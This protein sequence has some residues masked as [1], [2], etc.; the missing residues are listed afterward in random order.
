MYFAG[1][2]A[3]EKANDAGNGNGRLDP[4]ETVT[5]T[6]PLQNGGGATS[7]A[8]TATLTCATSGITILSGTANFSPI[9]AAGSASLSFSLSA[10]A[11]M[12]IGTVANL[13]I[14]TVEYAGKH[15][16]RNA[17]VAAH[18]LTHGRYKGA[19]WGGAIGLSVLT[20][21]LALIGAINESLGLLAVLAGVIAQASLLIYESAYV[22]AGQD[23]PLS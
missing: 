6:L 17:A 8:G 18:M 14:L 2:G 3:K 19:F 13:L 20:A 4:G 16:T 10:A 7:P 9:S 5:V 23:V 22:K 15:S 11:G 21:V 1:L 12:S